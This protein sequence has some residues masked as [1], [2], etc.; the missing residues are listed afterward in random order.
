MLKRILFFC[1]PVFLFSN[2]FETTLQDE[3]DWL[4]EETTVISA[5]KVKEDIDKTPASIS[6]I[7]EELIEKIGL[8]TLSDVLNT[9]AGINVT[10]SNI[11][12]K[13]IESR[14]IK[15]WF[16][17]QILF[18]VDGH[19][20]DANFINGGATWSYA[21]T[22][23]YNV[24]R[25]EIIKGPASSLYGANAFTALVNIIT[26]NIK[27]ID[28]V[29]T[30]IK[31]G[32]FNTTELNLLLGK[33][34][35][36]EVG[37]LANLNFYETDGKSIN[38]QSDSKGNSG[39]TNPYSK[40]FKADLKIDYDDFYLLFSY[41][42]REDGSHF[43]AA[44]AVNDETIAKNYYGFAEV[45]HEKDLT[46]ILNLKTKIYL[47]LYSF[48]NTWELYSEGYP[49]SSYTDGMKMINKV[50]NEKRGIETLA[51]FDASDSYILSLGAMYEKH[52]Q[53]DITTI[54]NFDPSDGSAL[55]QMTDYSNTNGTFAPDVSRSLKTIYLNNIY[56][57]S[58]KIR[59][60]VGAR[61]DE[62]DDFGSNLSFRG[63]VSNQINNN[64]T[65]KVMYGEG[66][67]APTFAELYN[68]SN[69]INGNSTLDAETVK[70]YEISLN[71]RLSNRWS[72]KTTT[73]NSDYDELIVLSG[74]KYINRDKTNTKGIE[75][76]TNYDLQRGSYINANYSYIVA[77]DE[78]SDSDL[79]DVARQKANLM[80]NTRINK[81]LN[82]FNHVRVKSKVKRDDSDPREDLA[83]YAV[84]NT[85]MLIK[86][87]YNKDTQLK[88]S[89]N[90]LLDKKYYDPSRYDSSHTN[91]YK[92]DY[93]NS[94][95]NFMFEIKHMF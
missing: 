28:G 61:Y 45:G 93:Q 8:N 17:K 92:D 34:V 10:Q 55:S 73:F 42:Q 11:F 82:L 69:V 86:N 12:L 40:R 91:L 33:E 30:V 62:Y 68:K 3:I 4:K 95:R 31:K 36:S 88:I 22:S 14:G 65:L 35:N 63:G 78:I 20:I 72:L 26:K 21:E 50:T 19:P 51:T 18:L 39:V 58:E 83:G 80:V 6:V 76:E 23:L 90:N 79:P 74:S 44:N 84:V 56:D 37:V 43:G 2:P 75:F 24:K 70:T 32:S 53:Y 77:K 94:G 9:V 5:S 85:S 52:K 64:N 89:I 71:S 25:I 16:S 47:D 81:N 27:D 59:I 87:F 54:Q 66:F 1:T 49:T 57:T 38:V 13:E 67:R 60:T 46:S 41:F 29:E 7:D 15:D 48:D